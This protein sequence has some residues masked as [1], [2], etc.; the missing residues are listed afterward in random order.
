[1]LAAWRLPNRFIVKGVLVAWRSLCGHL[2]GGFLVKARN[3]FRH[4]KATCCFCCS[5]LS[6]SVDP[7]S[8]SHSWSTQSAPPPLRHSQLQ[9]QDHLALPGKDVMEAHD[10]GVLELLE[11]GDLSLHLLAVQAQAAPLSLPHLHGLGGIEGARAALLAAPDHPKVP[12]E[13]GE[14]GEKGSNDKSTA[15]DLWSGPSSRG[16]RALHCLH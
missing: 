12:A 9:D 14:E 3:I 8:K 16:H 7:K 11:N 4:H 1:M 6:Q 10:V 13:W 15:R 2:H 5:R